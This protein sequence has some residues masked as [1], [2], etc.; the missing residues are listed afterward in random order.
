MKKLHMNTFGSTV[1]EN[2]TNIVKKKL[3]CWAV[4]L[5]FVSVRWDQFPQTNELNDLVHPV[6]KKINQFLLRKWVTTVQ[7]ERKKHE[8]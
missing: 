2:N 8:I 5:I 6:N 3:T 4:S 7:N 1:S